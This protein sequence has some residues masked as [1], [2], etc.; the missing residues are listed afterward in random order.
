MAPRV[1]ARKAPLVSDGIL[2]VYFV[3]F[4]VAMDC[5]DPDEEGLSFVGSECVAGGAAR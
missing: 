1:T 2:F 4:V 3:C 5:M